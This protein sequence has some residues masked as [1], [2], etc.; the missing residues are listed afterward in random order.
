M[1]I[2]LVSTAPP[3][4]GGISEHTKGLYNSLIKNHTVKIFTFYYQYPN[5]FFPGKYQKINGNQKFNN[6]Y[7][8]INS[9][10]PFSWLKTTNCIFCLGYSLA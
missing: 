10:N 8:S 7:Y 9:V 3:Y 1:N 5:F 6:T 4:R 2:I